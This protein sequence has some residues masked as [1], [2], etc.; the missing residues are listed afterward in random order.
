MPLLDK[1]QGGEAAANNTN[2]I[3]I[4]PSDVSAG[5]KDTPVGGRKPQENGIRESPLISYVS[6][7][8]TRSVMYRRPYEQMWL[9]NHRNY[10]GLYGPDLA[11]TATER[12]IKTLLLLITGWNVVEY[13]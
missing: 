5:L 13:K 6:Q 11:F 8:F 2:T 10:R 1:I 9:D 12:V 7:R 4:I 3:N